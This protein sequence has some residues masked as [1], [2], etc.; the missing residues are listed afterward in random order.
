MLVVVVFFSGETVD[1]T[2]IDEVL[3]EGRRRRNLP[4]LDELNFVLDQGLSTTKMTVMMMVAG[5]QSVQEDASLG[6]WA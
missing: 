6:S 4:R 3:I 5:V 2:P 1:E